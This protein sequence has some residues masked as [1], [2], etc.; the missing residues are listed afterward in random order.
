V[1]ALL[2]E[3]GEL[4]RW[5]EALVDRELVSPVED[6][7]FS[8]EGA[9]RFRHEILRDASYALLVAE[10]RKLGHRLAADWLERVGESDALTLAQHCER[11]EALGRALPHYLKAA[12]VALERGDLA[13]VLDLAE[14]A[15]R[16]GPDAQ[17]QGLLAA[18]EGDAHYWRG[19][20]AAAEQRYLSALQLVPRGKRRRHQVAAYLMIVWSATEALERMESLAQALV[21][22]D[23]V[24]EDPSA[25]AGAMATAAWRL[26]L[27]GRSGVSDRL[28]SA[29]AALVEE[30]DRADAALAAH[31]HRAR[32]A[33]ALVRA[34]DPVGFL[35]ETER[36]SQRFQEIGDER[37]T[38]FQRANVG[39]ALGTLGRWADAEKELRAALAVAERLRLDHVAYGVRSNL[40]LCLGHLGRIREA[41]T[42]EQRCASWFEQSGDR[43]LAG[44]SSVYQAIIHLM[45][46]E[47]E[48][49][50]ELA[51]A[52]L[53][54]P[55][56]GTQAHATA[57]LARVLLLR[58]KADEALRCAETARRMMEKESIVEGEASVRLVWA[59]TLRRRG[60]DAEAREAIGAARTQLLGRAEKISR[61]EWRES[62]LQIPD[63]ARTLELAARWLG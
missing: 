28:L 6:V 16:L 60:R 12:E 29:S 57:T 40:G 5:L 2:G 38:C 27:A 4:E 53:V 34:G 30:P 14:R 37:E 48:A 24:E 19:E 22:S 20:Y 45:A 23:D 46:G 3:S 36:C 39:Y 61:P 41:V 56:H 52:A 63:H 10:D 8:G 21:D 42:L 26:Y 49:A 54:Y 15:G 44:A 9:Y 1:T 25:R 35:E 47:L 32:A 59:E 43:R 18:L 58:G 7:R 31:V 17:A 62:F 50:E 51:R 13:A 55:N 33:R 11:G